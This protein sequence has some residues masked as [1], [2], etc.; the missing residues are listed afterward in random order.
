MQTCSHPK[1]LETIGQRLRLTRKPTRAFL[2]DTAAAAAAETRLDYLTNA[3]PQSSP[4]LRFVRDA[5]L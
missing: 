2:L 1:T 4:R 3:T 5:E